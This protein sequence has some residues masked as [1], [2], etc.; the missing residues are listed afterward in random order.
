MPSGDP[1]RRWQKCEEATPGGSQEPGTSKEQ[2]SIVPSIIPA[3]SLSDKT[4]LFILVLIMAFVAL[5]VAGLSVWAL[6]GAALD[7]EKVRLAGMARQQAHMIEA[8][9]RFDRKYSGNDHPEGAEAATM[10]QI[11][12]AFGEHEGFGETGEFVIGRRTGDNISFIIRQLQSGESEAMVSWDSDLAEPM[13][14]ALEGHSGTVMALDYG[15]VEVLAGYAPVGVLN[16]GFVAKVDLAE[17]R[18]PFLQA[19]IMSVAGAL[20]ILFVSTFLFR[21]ISAPILLREK[22]EAALQKSEA[23]IR[24]LN[25]ELEDRVKLRTNELREQKE[26]SDMILEAAGEGVYGV[27]LEGN[28]TFVNP[29]ACRMLGLETADMIGH[30]AHA[31]IHHTRVDGTPYP[32]EDCHIYRAYRDGSVQKASDEIFWRRDSTSFPVEYLST[33]IQKEGERLGAVVVFRD[34]TEARQLQAQVVQSSKLA[35]LGEMA[36]GVA[37][38]LNQPLSVIGMASENLIRRAHKGNLDEDYLISKLERICAQTRRAA[39]IIDHMR[40]FG[41]PVS[42]EAMDI[43]TCKVVQDALG[44]IGE[45]LRL[46]NIDVQIDLD[47]DCPPVRGHHVQLEQVLLNL[48]GN[49][50]DALGRNPGNPRKINISTSRLASGDQIG[51]EIGDT[52]GGIDAALLERIFEPF[53]TTKEVGQGTGLGLSISYGIIR[54]MGGTI[55]ARNGPDGA[56]FSVVL[57]ISR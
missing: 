16:F 41:R 51:I 42:G 57:P 31:L 7:A 40:I 49:A 27:D 35:T 47:P 50:Q 11:F 29:A 52:G 34:V 23:E 43:D 5:S 37:H 15:G 36:T 54:D 19:V 10:V 21:Y 13:R 26:F 32:A 39:Q 46:A 6:Y 48:L 33:P 44:L 56:I 24:E 4:R 14:L 22:A 53:F 3:S 2:A 45:Q 9:A 17:V 38:E 12:E 25:A 55:S 18:R 1:C 28:C 8:V 30:N 20:L